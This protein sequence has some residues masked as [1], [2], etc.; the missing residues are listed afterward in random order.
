MGVRRLLTV[1]LGLAVL[2]APIQAAQATDPTVTLSGPTTATDGDSLVYSITVH[3]GGGGN[4]SITWAPVGATP[5]TE[6]VADGVEDTGDQPLTYRLPMY[7]NTTVTATLGSVTSS[8]TVK[9]RPQISTIVRTPHQ[10]YR[11]YAV[12][13]AG[14]VPAF[15]STIA[16]YIAHRCLTFE[17][18]R[19]RSGVWRR[20]VL[21]GCRAEDSKGRVFWSWAGSH[22]SNVSFRIRS[23][24]RGDTE[25]VAANGPFTY[26]RFG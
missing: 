12:I 22:P 7:V 14:N 4:L 15:R 6:P 13:S 11:R 17:V 8:L 25:N 9:V 1:A 3:N 19:L 10:T 2:A 20:V 23:A 18:Q 24:F 5:V 21:T 26:F 16:P